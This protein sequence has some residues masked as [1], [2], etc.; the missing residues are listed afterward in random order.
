[1]PRHEPGGSSEQSRYERDYEPAYRFGWESHSRYADRQWEDVQEELQPTGRPTAI[2][3]RSRAT[4]A[5]GVAER[6]GPLLPRGR[7]SDQPG[8]EQEPPPPS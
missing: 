7:A 8:L 2:P 1:M 6:L 3:V 5:G 4:G